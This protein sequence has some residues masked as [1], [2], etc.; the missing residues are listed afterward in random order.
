MRLIIFLFISALA[1][2]TVLGQGQLSH[3]KNSEIKP[4]QVELSKKLKEI[5]G[6]ALSEDG[7]LFAHG[8][9]KGT[10]YQL[11]QLTGEIMKEFRIGRKKV[12]EDFEAIA[13][14]GKM[15]Y[16]VTSNGDIYEFEEG[17]NNEEVMFHLYKTELKSKFDVEGLCYDTNTNSLLLACK[18]FAGKK[19]D[20]SR[21]I[22]SFDLE[23][24]KLIENP[25]YII[26][27]NKLE[28]KWDVDNFK[29]SAIEQNPT[30]ET[31]FILGGKEL[32]LLELSTDG[33]VINEMVLN[34]KLHH[35]P[36][37]ITFL[38]DKTM[39]IS[40]EAD[41]DRATLTFYRYHNN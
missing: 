11:D 8:D 36:E 38:K 15:F 13:I 25:K 41:K 23:K 5:S 37:G 17:A 24:K 16:L 19:I 9:E 2:S 30:S 35:Q 3:Y 20:D 32:V 33:K 26:S 6:L 1:I 27:L 31:F 28:K 12:E 7:R 34:K 10:I 21:S 22:Y 40:D 18:E 29:P 14:V 39:V 4:R